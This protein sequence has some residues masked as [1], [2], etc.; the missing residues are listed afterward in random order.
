MPIS[1]AELTRAQRTR[2]AVTPIIVATTAGAGA[3]P[4]FNTGSYAVK[5]T[6]IIL[7]CTT[8]LAVADVSLDIGRAISPTQAAAANAYNAIAAS[9][10]YKFLASTR[11]F[12]NAVVADVT[13]GEKSEWDVN[14]IVPKNTLVVYNNNSSGQAGAYYAVVEFER[15]DDNPP[16]V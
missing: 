1:G 5:I 2:S 16:E 4:L 12:G 8:T 7:H 9:T 11:P 15:I 6:R 3:V 13:A 10:P 14:H